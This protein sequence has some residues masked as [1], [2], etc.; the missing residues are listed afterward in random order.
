MLELILIEEFIYKD[1]TLHTSQ[2]H[3]CVNVIF[4]KLI[5]VCYSLK[6]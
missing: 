6:C 3:V 1:K 2:F 5:F 4:K